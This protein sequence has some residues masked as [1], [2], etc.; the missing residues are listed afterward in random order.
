M[1]TDPEKG[2]PTRVLVWSPRA[3]LVQMLKTS[4]AERGLRA[5]R[6]GGSLTESL[7]EV[8][9]TAVIVD[10]AASKK[11]AL[12]ACAGI[13]Q[14]Q[15][16]GQP[17][18]PVF[19]IAAPADVAT[20]KRAIQLGASDFSEASDSGELLALRIEAMVCA[21]RERFQLHEEADRARTRAGRDGL[22]GLAGRD[23]FTQ[24]MD[25]A[26]RRARRDDHPAALLYIDLDR[27]KG[28][29]DTLGHAVGDALLQEVARLL[30]GE[31]RPTDVVS[32]GG[33]Q[34]AG[35]VSRLGGDEFT[36]LLSKV[37]QARDAGD[38]ARR[39]LDAVNTPVSVAGYEISTTAS[40]GIAV[41]P[42]DGD[43]AETLL[44]RADMAMYGAKA[45]GPG[46]YEFYQPSMGQAFVRR[47]DL[48]KHLR[49]A[50]ERDE[51]EMR[52]QPRIDIRTGA[53]VGMEALIRWN[54]PQLGWV[55]PREFIPV[56]EETRLIVPIGAWVIETA[57]A[58]LALW[59]R[60]G[61]SGLRLSVNVSSEQFV[62]SDLTKTV[63]DTLR[64]T[65]LKP[66]AL[67]LEVTESLMVGEDNRT[68]LALRDLRAIGVALA[69]DDFGTGYSSLSFLTRFPLDV[70]KIDRSIASG[71]EDDPAAASIVEAVV[72][73]G[74]RLGL[75]IVAEGV[76]SAGQAE[77]I[78][79]LGCDEIQG[80]LISQPLDA[81]ELGD[82]RR[83]WRS[84][85]DQSQARSAGR[86]GNLVD[87]ASWSRAIGGITDRFRRG[88]R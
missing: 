43:D 39:I 55:Q 36:V 18:T 69:L 73:M 60:I 75:R 3:E 21:A 65:G 88:G 87:K 38:V 26:L 63:T 61:W 20:I 32:T 6:A 72:A 25:D 41:F 58:Q 66:G 78:R 29:N 79:E 51:F 4:L 83:Y 80:F 12:E 10:A 30:K 19:L 53:M 28:V 17:R 68:A 74:S 42:Q 2:A 50:L 23:S 8:R 57:C 9:P 15:R 45:K 33:N 24:S 59:Q 71:V 49:H 47:I 35:A 82:F 14:H 37:R 27:F 64:A 22:T 44:K 46:R 70:L 34:R 7:D 13:Q 48:E 86:R 5:F 85:Q 62:S 31:V 40:I 54:S 1:S 11:G 84:L 77:R 76:D 56:A 81:K 67:E 16:R 52:Y